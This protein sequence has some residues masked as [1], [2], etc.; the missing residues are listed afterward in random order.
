MPLGSSSNQFL[1]NPFAPG[2]AMYGQNTTDAYENTSSI[3]G[4][5]LGN[6]K[7][8]YLANPY[9]PGGANWG[10]P[11]RNTV[12][13][14]YNNNTQ[15]QI[16]D[17]YY[18]QK[19]REQWAPV[20][21]VQ[22]PV[23]SGGGDLLKKLIDGLGKGGGDDSPATPGDG[24]GKVTSAITAGPV[25]TP[26]QVASGEAAIRGGAQAPAA[27][28]AMGNSTLDRM[29]ADTMAQ[30]SG[31]D[32]VDFTRSSAYA[33]AQQQLASQKAQAQSG[34]GNAQLLARLEAMKL[35]QKAFD[36]SFLTD[37][38]GGLA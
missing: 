10:E 33:N 8:N 38:L 17:A 29:Y 6:S 9:A 13:T 37:L 25:W 36:N 1:R 21:P 14:R 35:Q 16:E 28:G 19:R 3:N 22:P 23:Q 27:V 31:R 20:A 4:V 12:Q 18:N 32:A 7:S 2:G 26:A 30:N 11:A 5:A 24:L 15:R 34:L